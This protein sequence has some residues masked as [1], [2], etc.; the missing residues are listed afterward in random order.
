[1]LLAAMQRAGTVDDTTKIAQAL[2]EIHYDGYGEDDTYFDSRHL[3][4]TG[5]DACKVYQG[6]M[7]CQHYPPPQELP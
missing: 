3:I 5:N 7:T 2:E 1:M 4:V 6:E